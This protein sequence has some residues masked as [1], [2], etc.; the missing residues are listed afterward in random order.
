[1]SCGVFTSST[2]AFAMAHRAANS[3]AVADI[4]REYMFNDFDKT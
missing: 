4:E 3:N 1:V 2:Q